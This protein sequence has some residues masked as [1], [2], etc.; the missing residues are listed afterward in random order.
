MAQ[1]LE[2]EI[3]GKFGQN[4]VIITLF[5]GVVLLAS[6]SFSCNPTTTCSFSATMDTFPDLRHHA[7]QLIQ[8]T[9]E[10]CVLT[11]KN[12]L[13]QN[14]PLLMSVWSEQ[15]TADL[16]DYL[17]HRRGEGSFLPGTFHDLAV[18][19]NRKYPGSDRSRNSVLSKFGTV[20]TFTIQ[21]SNCGRTHTSTS[22]LK[23]DIA[24]IDRYNSVH[25]GEPDPS[26]VFV[27]DEARFVTYLSTSTAR[28]NTI[29]FLS[30]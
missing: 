11:L 14:N 6:G 5:K 10:L 19:L 23:D 17:Y 26:V 20:R 21:S 3:F 18:Y 9:L 24:I 12:S 13:N 27:A 28:V 15:E 8:F 4:L 1:V 2:I 7:L 25:V 16:V 29:A 30:V 22:Q